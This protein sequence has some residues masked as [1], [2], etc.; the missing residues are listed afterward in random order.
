MNPPLLPSHFPQIS[1]KIQH[2]NG[3][4]CVEVTSLL[5][6]I[7]RWKIPKVRMQ[8][9]MV[10]LCCIRITGGVIQ[11][12]IFLWIDIFMQRDDD[13]IGTLTIRYIHKTMDGQV[14][15]IIGNI[16]AFK[17]IE[18]VLRIVY[19]ST[20]FVSLKLHQTWSLAN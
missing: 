6:F 20:P 14:V 19:T 11:C 18:G 10:I 13:Q 12:L 5:S 15:T 16:V 1:Q 17:S 2:V 8:H 3:I 9:K 4:S 7:R